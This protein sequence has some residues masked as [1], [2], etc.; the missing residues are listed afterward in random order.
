MAKKTKKKTPKAEKLKVREVSSLET[1]VGALEIRIDALINA[2]KS[3]KGL[4]GI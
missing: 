4:K 3:S 2:I 1:R